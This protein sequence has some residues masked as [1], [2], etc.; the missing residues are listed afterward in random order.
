MEY[1]IEPKR[2]RRRLGRTRKTRRSRIAACPWIADRLRYCHA[3]EYRI[4][5]KRVIR[6]IRKWLKAGIL[7]GS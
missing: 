3:L 5:D 2:R 1:P 7:V 6:L 4:G